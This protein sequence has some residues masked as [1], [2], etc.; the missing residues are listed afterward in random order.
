MNEPPEC[1]QPT[2]ASHKVHLSHRLTLNRYDECPM[3]EAHSDQILTINATLRQHRP[4]P[5]F[6]ASPAR[7][8][9]QE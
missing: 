1:T 6:P 2:N 7:L 9:A 5:L 8:N 4:H 3:S